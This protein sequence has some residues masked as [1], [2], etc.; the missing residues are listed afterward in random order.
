MVMPKGV[1]LHEWMGTSRLKTE[2]SCDHSSEAIDH[3]SLV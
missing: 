1:L 3:D 2:L